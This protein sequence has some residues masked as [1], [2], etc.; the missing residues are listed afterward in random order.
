MTKGTI[1]KVKHRSWKNTYNLYH[2]KGQISLLTKNPYRAPRKIPVTL[3]KTGQRTE[4]TGNWRGNTHDSQHVQKYTIIYQTVEELKKKKLDWHGS[5][6]RYRNTFSGTTWKER[7]LA[8]P[9]HVPL[10]THTS[11]VPA[12]SLVGNYLTDKFT[13]MLRGL[14]PQ[15]ILIHCQQ[16][17][18]I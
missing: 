11:C 9:T 15:W 13:H 4:T 18:K 1:N 8:M 16:Q 17:Q 3:Q 6:G 2:E 12:F 10:S 14:N 7:A 5:Q